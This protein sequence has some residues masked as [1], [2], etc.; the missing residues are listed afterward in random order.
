MYQGERR[1][2]PRVCVEGIASPDPQREQ[3]VLHMTSLSRPTGGRDSA[4]YNR[5]GQTPRGQR[6][7]TLG[8]TLGRAVDTPDAVHYG[9]D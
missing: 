1:S 6:S 5:F 7:P 8:W 9:V 3:T 2:K 4:A